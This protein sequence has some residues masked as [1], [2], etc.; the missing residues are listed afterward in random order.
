MKKSTLGME[1]SKFLSQETWQEIDSFFLFLKPNFKKTQ[2][3]RRN[4]E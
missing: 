1:I 3:H 4:P 2:A